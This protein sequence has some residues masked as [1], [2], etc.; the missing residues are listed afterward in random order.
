M[1]TNPY[2]PPTAV[3]ADAQQ[4][5]GSPAIW[6]P[7]A[8]ANWSL[9]FSPAFGAFLH[10]L[11]WRALGELQR[12]ATARLWFIAA[13]CMLALYLVLGLVLADFRGVEGVTRALGFGF[14]LVWYFSAARGQAKFVKEKFGKSYPRKGWAKPLLIALAALAGY[15][16]VAFLI[17]LVLGLMQRG[18]WGTLP[19]R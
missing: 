6:N 15:I 16:L 8:A 7:N 3:V 18:I 4:S 2:A 19:S 14:L 12:E 1:T 10:M 11:N 13:L 5:E 9:L 17:G